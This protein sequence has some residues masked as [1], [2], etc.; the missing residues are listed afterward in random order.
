MLGAESGEASGGAVGF[1]LRM[2]ETKSARLFNDFKVH[3]EEA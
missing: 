1:D 2:A 3:L